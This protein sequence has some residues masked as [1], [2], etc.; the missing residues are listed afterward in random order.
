ME[1]DRLIEVKLPKLTV[2][3]TTGEI[4]AL[5]RQDTALWAESVRRGKYILRARKQRRREED[6]AE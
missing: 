5:L 1:N 4:Q 6:K 3:L 2:F